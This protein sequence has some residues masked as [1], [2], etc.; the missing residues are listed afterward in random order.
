MT[1]LYL[2]QLDILPQISS[3]CG[4]QIQKEFTFLINKGRMEWHST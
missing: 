2:Q 3:L 4:Q 1:T